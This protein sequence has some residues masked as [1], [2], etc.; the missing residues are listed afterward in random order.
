MQFVLALIVWLLMGFILGWGLLLFVKGA[1][2][3][4]LVAS[5]A[6]FAILMAKIGCLSH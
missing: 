5:V 1:T 3:W 6:V 2:V 4:V